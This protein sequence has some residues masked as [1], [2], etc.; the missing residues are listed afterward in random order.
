MCCS[1]PK[2]REQKS[3]VVVPTAVKHA[4]F[5]WNRH[6]LS[7]H[8][9]RSSAYFLVHQ[10][11]IRT[12]NTPWWWVVLLILCFAKQTNKQTNTQSHH[13]SWRGIHR[14]PSLERHGGLVCAC[15]RNVQYGVIVSPQE[16][17]VCAIISFQPRSQPK[18]DDDNLKFVRIA[19]SVASTGALMSKLFD[20]RSNH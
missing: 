12:R 4:R 2:E 16:E 15:V 14:G 20:P 11:V 3:T 17:C 18:R 9:I 7:V 6:A 5:L 10:R 8:S 1:T 19:K 13:G